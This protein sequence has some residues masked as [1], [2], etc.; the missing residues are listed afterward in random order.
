MEKVAHITQNAFGQNRFTVH[1]F[2]NKVIRMTKHCVT[3]QA[4]L[5]WLSLNHPGVKI[6]DMSWTKDN[7]KAA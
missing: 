2:K 1:I 3:K 4:A 6:V 7:V 5:D